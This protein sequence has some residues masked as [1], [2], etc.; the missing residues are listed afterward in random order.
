MNPSSTQAIMQ[1][2][3]LMRR[4]G[5]SVDDYNDMLMAQSGGCAICGGQNI[6]GRRLAVDHDH[7]TGKVRGLLCDKCN[8]G[9]GNFQDNIVYLKE[10]I[11]YLENV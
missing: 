10:A 3:H 5:L 6:K 11:N 8:R 7:A 1:R 2:H 4:Y 9:L